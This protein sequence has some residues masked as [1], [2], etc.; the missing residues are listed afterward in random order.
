MVDWTDRDD[1]MNWVDKDFS[2]LTTRELYQILRV[3][4]EVFI[5]EQ[6]SLLLDADGKDLAGTHVLGMDPAEDAQQVLAY[7]RLLPG[8]GSE[9]RIDKFLTRMSRRGDGTAEALMRSAQ[10]A[11]QSRWPGAPVGIQVP[12]YL[13]EFCESFGFIKREGPYLEHGTHFIGMV[14]QPP[15]A[16]ARLFRLTR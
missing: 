12:F 11:I 5:V 3:R 4:G 10:E 7:A 8:E 13:R 14:W 15:R 9:V 6:G 1:G 2:E 16:R